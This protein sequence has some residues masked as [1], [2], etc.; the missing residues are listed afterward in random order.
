MLI[1]VKEPNRDAEV[2][3]IENDE[4]QRQLIVGGSMDAITLMFKLDLIFNEEFLCDE[5][6]QK[7]IMIDGQIYTGTVFITKADENG[8]YIS[9][10]EGEIRIAR[11]L[12]NRFSL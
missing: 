1:V 3:E 2:R 7:N 9:L 4:S 6:F 8:E 11:M 5:E 12:L 10:K